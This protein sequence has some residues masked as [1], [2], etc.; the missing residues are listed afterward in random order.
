MRIFVMALL[1]LSS[2]SA[3]AAAL[4][5]GSYFVTADHLNVRLSPSANGKLTNKLSFGA[6]VDVEEVR[7]GW[8]RISKYYDGS[9]EGLNGTV[10][11]WVSA[12]YLSATKP[13]AETTSPASGPLAEALSQSNDYRK[14]SSQFIAASKKLIEQGK[15]TLGDFKEMGGWVRSTNN[16][17]KP[18]YFTYCGGFT[19]QNRIYLNVANGKVFK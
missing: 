4:G 12:K 11:R 9:V 14:Y 8:A 5:P 16:G 18:I 10:A 17:S 1:A 13:K 3:F 2:V 15:C 19:K 7:S 6:R